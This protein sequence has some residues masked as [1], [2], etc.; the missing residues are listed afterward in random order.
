[1]KNVISIHHLNCK[2]ISI[3]FQ[4]IYFP[5]NVNSLIDCGKFILILLNFD[6]EHFNANNNY[7][8]NY[9]SNI[10]CIESNTSTIKWTSSSL[11]KTEEY[12][13]YFDL[14]GKK[15]YAVTNKKNL[16]KLD[17]FTGKIHKNF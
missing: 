7:V 17:I 14:V 1:M 13:T 12:F 8:I 11:H 3:N 4:N 10:W 16:Y 6:P 9:Y 5:S 2:T 15:I